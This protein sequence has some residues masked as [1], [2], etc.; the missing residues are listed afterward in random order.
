MDG[1]FSPPG[2]QSL[3]CHFLSSS[4]SS[5]FPL[6]TDQPISEAL[7]V[8]SSSAPPSLNSD[9]EFRQDCA[10]SRFSFKVYLF[11]FSHLKDREALPFLLFGPK[12]LISNQQNS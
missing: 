8:P 9:P 2:G 7:A 11:I 10:S 5:F 1:W 6:L 3:L 4:S 12:Q